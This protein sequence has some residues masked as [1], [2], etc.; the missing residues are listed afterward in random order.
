[1][2]FKIEFLINLLYL[3]P[4]IILIMEKDKV[5]KDRSYYEERLRAYLK[6]NH[7]E[8]ADNMDFIIQRAKM[9]DDRFSQERL[10]GKSVTEASEIATEVLMEDL[11]Q[12]KYN[13]IEYVLEEE[14]GTP[15]DTQIAHRE[16]II[17]V[18]L[19]ECRGLFDKYTYG[20]KDF[21][22]TNDYDT[23]YAELA[24]FA[25]KYITHHGIQ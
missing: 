19:Q 15:G 5:I 21:L 25:K 1:M 17:K 18:L 16:D 22:S 13:I 10:M 8:E 4:I 9:A 3:C 2:K 7:F 23:L 6:E 14:Y 20:S 12:S 11:Y 24:I